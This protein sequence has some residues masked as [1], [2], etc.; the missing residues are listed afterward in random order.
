MYKIHAQLL[1]DEQY[2]HGDNRWCENDCFVQRLR[3]VIVYRIISGICLIVSSL[4]LPQHIRANERVD[5]RRDIRPLL[6]DACFHCHGPDEESQEAG[7][8][9]DLAAEATESAIVPGDPD[10]SEVMARILSTD[11]DEVMP[12][13]QSGKSLTKDQIELIRRWIEQ[14]AKYEQHWAF[15]KP[16]RPSVPPSQQTQWVTNPIDAFVWK[17]LAQEGIRPSPRADKATLL[18]RLHLDLIGLPPTP[19]Q[20]DAFLTAADD[21][22]ADQIDQLLQ[23]QHFGERWARIWL[24]AA[25]YADSNG[26]EKDT[27]RQMWFYRDWV[28]NALSSD[29]PYD[30]FVIHQ[31]AGDLLPDA[32]QNERVATGFLR[33]SMI[34]EEG[35]AD[36]EQFRM[37]AMYDRMDAIGKSVLGLT[38]QCAQCHSHKYDPLTQHEY[39]EMFAFLNNTHDAI[40]PVYTP[41]ETKQ[42]DKVLDEIDKIQQQLKAE[43]PDWRER[44]GVWEESVGQSTQHWEVLKPTSLPYE[45]QKFRVLGDSS[46]LSE[47]YAPKTSAPNIQ[48]Q[49]RRR[50]LPVSVSSC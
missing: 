6:S 36:P 40:I 41:E 32:R 44:L 5:F 18:R 12:P 47:S 30:Q 33:N 50:G 26:Y 39:Y 24:D 8:R 45:G 38:V 2:L 48:A 49:T 23:S 27:P 4:A 9:L 34:N 21:P 46:I 1:Q 16:A 22:Y 43:M 3:N 11:Q 17:R 14:G 31:I 13:P 28:I 42:R 10:D 7:L 15:V 19:E 25:R 37:E 35:G 29:M 20:V